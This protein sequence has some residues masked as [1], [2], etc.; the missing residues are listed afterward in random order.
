MQKLNRDILIVTD[1]NNEIG[2]IEIS[3]SIIQVSTLNNLTCE[4]KTFMPIQRW[5]L[6]ENNLNST[7]FKNSS[8]T[9]NNQEQI[10]IF[11]LPNNIKEKFEILQL[12]TVFSNENIAEIKREKEK[13]YSTAINSIE[14][15]LKEQYLLSEDKFENLDIVTGKANLEGVSSYENENSYVGLHI[16]NWDLLPL[17]ERKKSRKLFCVNLGAEPRYF[18]YCNL[19]LS[20]IADKLTQSNKIDYTNSE[21]DDIVIEFCKKFPDYPF[22]RF[23]LNPYQAYITPIQNMIH[24]GSTLGS[25]STDIYLMYLGYFK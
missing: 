16:D 8:D 5:H 24:E 11:S 18:I 6:I 10:R 4:D 23:T 15:Y 19:T 25:T 14:E 13:E 2:N 3:H 1:N 9:S 20:T 12:K 7:V 22:L 17:Y 21:P